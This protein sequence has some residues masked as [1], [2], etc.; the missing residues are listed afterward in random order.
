[1]SLSLN[2]PDYSLGRYNEDHPILQ[3]MKLRLNEVNKLA[4]QG[5]QSWE[6]T[7]NLLLQTLSSQPQ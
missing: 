1:M 3:M 6:L 4:S 2:L 5:V 7:P